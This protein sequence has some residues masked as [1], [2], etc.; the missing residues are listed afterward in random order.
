M[1][2]LSRGKQCFF[3]LIAAISVVV[4]I[5]NICWVSGADLRSKIQQIPIPIPGLS[6]GSDSDPNV[7][8]SP[9]FSMIRIP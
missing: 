7:R 8:R 4:F 6:K 2:G 5:V 3:Q 1:A 9:F